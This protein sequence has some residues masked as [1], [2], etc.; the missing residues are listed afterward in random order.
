MSAII[1]GR[2]QT[3]SLPAPQNKKKNKDWK[4]HRSFLEEG[5]EER[6]YKKGT[7]RRTIELASIGMNIG[8]K[9]VADGRLKD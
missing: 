9:N 8:A 5:E 7:K 4:D 3:T 6:K 1:R 2:R